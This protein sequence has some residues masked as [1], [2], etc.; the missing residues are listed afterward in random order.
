[1]HG[2]RLACA[3]PVRGTCTRAHATRTCTCTC[4]REVEDGGVD[5]HLVGV[6]VAV[7]R[8]RAPWR[9]PD[10]RP[11]RRRHGG[12]G[13]GGGGGGG[14]VAWRPGPPHNHVGAWQST[15]RA[16]G[17]PS[18]SGT[19]PGL[20]WRPLTVEAEVCHAEAFLEHVPVSKTRW[21]SL[22]PAGSPEA[23]LSAR[24]RL[25]LPRAP[26]SLGQS[27]GWSAQAGFAPIGLDFGMGTSC[28]RATSDAKSG[29]WTGVSHRHVLMAECC[30]GCG[31]AGEMS[32]I[33]AISAAE[34]KPSTT[35]R[36][37]APKHLFGEG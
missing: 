29:R 21:L 20:E 28:A 37:H 14:A 8:G 33:S 30:G 16:R 22:R 23:S 1:M 27:A 9:R 34:A 17:R 31:S 15:G 32:S 12:G 24:A 6:G 18:C 35:P 25:R 10:R 11:L 26:A 2:M 7:Q 5:E 36:T 4:L 19:H 3:W 13:S